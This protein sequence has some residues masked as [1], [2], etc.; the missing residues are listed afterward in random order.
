MGWPD[1]DPRRTLRVMTTT[2][3]QTQAAVNTAVVAAF[4]R[5]IAA[6]LCISA[7]TVQEHLTGVFDKVG[8]RSRRELASAL[9][10]LTGGVGSE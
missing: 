10:G 2:P 6:D 4:T 8:V 3:N 5:Q 9:L 1:D 7:Y